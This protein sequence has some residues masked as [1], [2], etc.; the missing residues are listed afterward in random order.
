[1]R[2]S[3]LL[4]VSVIVVATPSITARQARAQPVST[5]IFDGIQVVS[6]GRTGE[7]RIS[8]TVPIR[9]LRHTPRSRGDSVHIQFFPL[10]VT[11][12]GGS[13]FAGRESI[14]IPRDFP[15]PIDEVTYQGVVA[16]QPFLDVRFTRPLHFEVRQGEDLRSLVIAFPPEPGGAP[17]P[18]AARSAAPDGRIAEMMEEGRRAM[19]AG[20]LDRAVL[21]YTKVLSLPEHSESPAAQE[22]LALARER[23]G[24]L[25]H[26]KAEYEA[27]LE[28]YPDGESA[29]RVRQRL[30]ALVTSRA[31]PIEPKREKPPET[32]PWD[33]RSFGSIYAGYR[34]EMLFP[35]GE[36]S[37]LADSSFF[38]D[39]HLETRLRT[40]RYTARTQMTGGWR[41]EF[42]DG[43]SDETRTNSLFIEAEDHRHGLT[44]SIG[45]R[46]LSTSGV[47]GRFDGIRLTYDVTDRWMLGVVGGLPVDSAEDG[48]SSMDR[49]F[50]GVSLDVARFADAVDAQVYAIGQMDGGVT[51]RAA[52]GGEIRYFEPGRFLAAFLDYDVYFLDLNLAQIVGNWQV[53]PSTLLTTFLAH[54]RVPTLSIRNALQG[55]AVDDISDLL[56]SFSESE[57][58]RFAEDRTA[59]STTLNFGVNRDL[60]HQLQ[61]AVDFSA[62]DYSGTDSSGGVDGIDGTGFEFSYGTQL[63]KNDFLKTA[64]VGILGVRYFDGST[65]DLAT[66]TLDARYPITRRFRA[67]PRVRA[68]YRIVSDSGDVFSLL[69]S[70]RLDFQIWKLT[71][72]AEVTSEWRVPMQSAGGD[73]RWG[74][75][76]TF[77]VRYDY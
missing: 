35:D 50:A 5:R 13:A 61:L 10:E 25:A 22:F 40:D 36:A 12:S 70:L 24:Q 46:S 6:S 72:D 14:Q 28:R 27:Y 37:I 54:R 18:R 45:R 3:L 48:W 74:Y 65:S 56:D 59:R 8:F 9:Y 19:T 30:D 60:G 63:I 43:G 11:A 76:T 67:N 29:D 51:D 31:E 17:P 20:E 32:R 64:G 52:V 4:A 2:T 75:S 69:P 41:H 77:G 68:D 53:T 42:L 55:Q 44:G 7:A 16:G 21:I 39:L 62:S 71:F 58:K 23:K 34:R 1:M 38:T 15:L 33:L 73:E 66:V 49:Y 57:V 26:A 47:L